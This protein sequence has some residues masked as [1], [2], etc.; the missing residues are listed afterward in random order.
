MTHRIGSFLFLFLL[1]T[2]TAFSAEY[3]SSQRSVVPQ[4]IVGG[5]W[6]TTI[7]LHNRI[8][9]PRTVTVR[10]IRS[11]AS[12][13]DLMMPHFHRNNNLLQ[14]TLQPNESRYIHFSGGAST[15]FGYAIFGFPCEDSKN[16]ICGDITGNVLLRNHND[17]R[18]QDFELSYNLTE[19]K[20][21]MTIPFD[22]TNWGQVVMNLSNAHSHGNLYDTVYEVTVYDELN[23]IK[24]RKD[25]SL[26]AGTSIIVNMAHES[27]ATWNVRGRLEARVKTGRSSEAVLL[28]GLRINETG[29]FTPLQGQ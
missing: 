14:T 29:S 8:N 23:T 5:E 18:V 2:A 25:Y 3:V 11:D 12:E 21:I 15:S 28:S 19:T 13:W 6:T 22:Q 4:I 7:M 17:A 24:F 27:Q 1:L 10:L 9:L 20:K 16:D 26:N